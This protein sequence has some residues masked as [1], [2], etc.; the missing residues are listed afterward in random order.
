MGLTI[1]DSER[2]TEERGRELCKRNG[3]TDYTRFS[4]GRDA[5]I[6]KFA[7]TYAIISDVTE[8]GYGDRWCFETYAK[9]RESLDE[10]KSRDGE[11]E[12]SL[13]HRHPSS[14]RRRPFGDASQEY[15]NP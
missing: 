4:G 7:F 9:A 1:H 5:A 11:G 3:Y 13:W 14:G 10:W 12:P 8:W 15:I 6:A 2:L